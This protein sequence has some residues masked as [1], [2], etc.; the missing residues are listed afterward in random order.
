MGLRRRS[1]VLMWG[2]V[3]QGF[4]VTSVG[5]S[6]ALQPIPGVTF[7]PISDEAEPVIFSAVCWEDALLRTELDGYTDYARPTRFRLVPGIW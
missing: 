1:S 5:A 2:M 7:L 3:A 4:D 6:V